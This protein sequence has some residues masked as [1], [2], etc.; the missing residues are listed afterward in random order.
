MPKKFKGLFPDFFFFAFVFNELRLLTK[1][2]FCCHFLCFFC[3]LG[4]SMTSKEALLLMYFR[5]GNGKG[6]GASFQKLKNFQIS[7]L[8]N[9][10][11]SK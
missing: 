10:I 3:E 2:L 6:Q 8:E 7:L 11:S 9:F 4:Q 5:I 1:G